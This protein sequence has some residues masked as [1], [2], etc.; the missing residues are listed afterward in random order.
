MP[1]RRSGVA[2]IFN[3][4]QNAL[5]FPS[6]TGATFVALQFA[7]P[8]S[9]GL[10]FYGPSSNGWSMVWETKYIQQTGYYAMW[11]W[12][13][14]GTFLWNSG[15]SDTY[16][17]AH[18]YP[19]NGTGSD[20]NHVWELAGM[21]TAADNVLTRAGTTKSVV[22]GTQFVQGFIMDGSA[23]KGVFYTA[24]PSTANADV[25]EHT[26]PGG[27]GTTNPPSPCLTF[28]DS[29]WAQGQERASCYFRRLKIFAPALS[30]SDL[31]SEAGD[32]SRI[33]TANGLS[34]I[35]YGKKNWRS[36]DD[37]TC[38][39]NTARALVWAD[40]GNKATLIPV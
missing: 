30:E 6:N 38:D 23:K 4:V 27:F 39:Y 40:S 1:V 12:S 8:N 11:W 7:N 20:T 16:V 36:I 22:K 13:N 19:A 26:A 28:G 24:L 32:M 25:I 21:E 14:N 15:S 37:L 17:G 33:V 31:I 10:P 5:L 18:P 29:P 35:W 3:E 2:N 34:S 9:N